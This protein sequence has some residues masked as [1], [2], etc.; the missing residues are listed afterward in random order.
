MST[1]KNLLPPRKQIC[2]RLGE[3]AREQR[4]LRDL[5]KISVRAEEA[6]ELRQQAAAGSTGQ[7]PGGSSE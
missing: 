1:I 5:L 4:M 7:H 6:D 3:I 2:D